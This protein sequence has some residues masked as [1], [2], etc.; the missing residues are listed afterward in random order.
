VRK[1]RN[2]ARVQPVGLADAALG[3]ANGLRPLREA[4]SGDAR[5]DLG[6]RQFAR[7]AADRQ[8]RL[9]DAAPAL[10]GD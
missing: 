6:R 5:F 2:Q 3:V 1:A 8:R 9:A 10:G 7:K 4:K